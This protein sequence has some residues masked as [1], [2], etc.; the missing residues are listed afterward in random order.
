MNPTPYEWVLPGM[1]SEKEEL[2]AYEK[3]ISEHKI[4]NIVLQNKDLC[5][6]DL[7]FSL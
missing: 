4:E 1:L 3:L 5:H 2:K 7:P 6:N